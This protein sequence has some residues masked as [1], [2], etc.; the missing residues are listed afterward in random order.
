MPDMTNSA[1]DVV[2]ISGARILALGTPGKLHTCRSKVQTSSG[3]E[4]ANNRTSAGVFFSSLGPAFPIVST[5]P[6]PRGRML[7][8]I[9]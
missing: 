6:S 9:E 3:G 5:S 4:D 1:T 7:K 8:T 2:H